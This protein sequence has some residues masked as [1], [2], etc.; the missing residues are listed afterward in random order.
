MNAQFKITAIAIFASCFLFGTQAQINLLSN[1]I[2]FR[3]YSNAN[4]ATYHYGDL[5]LEGGSSGSS[6]GWLYTNAINCFGWVNISE[7][8]TIHGSAI[9]YGDLNVAG[10]KNF[11]QPHPTDSTKLI[12]YIAIESG[13]A[14]TLARGT[15]KTVNGQVTIALPDHFSLVTSNNA[16]ITVLVTPKR[17]PAL[18][19]IKEESKEQIV[20][21]MKESDFFEFHDVEFTFQVTGVRD[22]FE[23]E[24]IIVDVAKKNGQENISAKRAA[25]NEKVK[26]IAEKIKQE[27]KNKNK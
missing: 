17:V 22:G 24:E 5:R 27:K 12:K 11:I 7:W 10:S 26:V 20:V 23:D 25:Y 13:E 3:S 14:L 16:P 18:L 21:A 9:I 1:D 4:Q 2:Q 15:S 8:A 19:Y 6:Y